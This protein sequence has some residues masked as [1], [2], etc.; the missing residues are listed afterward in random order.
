MSSIKGQTLPSL[1][2][3]RFYKSEG[4]VL[5][6]RRKECKGVS[7]QVKRRIEKVSRKNCRFNR[8]ER[9]EM[10]SGDGGPSDRV[11]VNLVAR[12]L[13]YPPYVTKPRD[14]T[15]HLHC[16]QEIQLIHLRSK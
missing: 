5:R 14:K 1:I 6:A 8:V 12:V 4:E 9:K 10:T 16:E 3:L 11:I 15:W 13:S 2:R 7:E